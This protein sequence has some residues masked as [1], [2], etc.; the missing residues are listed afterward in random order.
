MANRKRPP[1]T[2]NNNGN[3]S[4]NNNNGT[5][6]AQHQQQQQLPLP[7]GIDTLLAKYARHLPPGGTITIQLIKGPSTTSV[8]PIAARRAAAKDAAK[9]KRNGGGSGNDSDDDNGGA[10]VAKKGKGITV[11]LTFPRIAKF[12]ET[13]TAPDFVRGSLRDGRFYEEEV[14]LAKVSSIM[15]FVF[16]ICM[17]E[18]IF[19]G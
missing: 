16:Y 5:P 15:D 8:D 14:P 2:N 11:P 10:K 12:N 3:A 17:V 13:V 18:I 1:P 7:S 4:T 6:A 9:N 19:V